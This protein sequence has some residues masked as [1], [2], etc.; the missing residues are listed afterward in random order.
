AVRLNPKHLG[1][2]ANLALILKDL[3]RLEEAQAMYREMIADAPNYP[4]MCMDMGTLAIECEGDLEAARRWFRKAQ[5]VS[6]NPRAFFSEA[7]VN[8]I[9]NKFDPGWTQYEARK[10]VPDQRPQQE[11]FQRFPVW[12]GGRLEDEKL[13][14]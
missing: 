5:T 4:K 6:D 10:K 11:P 2:R 1:L 8:L 7:I 14:L 13:L 9:E 3:G 12:Q